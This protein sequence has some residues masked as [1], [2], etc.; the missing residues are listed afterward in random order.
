[1][2]AVF[3]EEQRLFQRT[4]REFLEKECPPKAVR[5]AVSAEAGWSFERW[6]GLADLGVVGLTAPEK[7]GGLGKDETDLV[8]LLEE[9]GRAAL[10]E[11][12][13]ET[14]AVAIPMLS[15]PITEE[16]LE[17]WLARIVS[18][19]AIATLVPTT[20]NA[21]H[22]RLLASDGTQ[23]NLASAEAVL[24]GEAVTQFDRA[25]LATAAELCGI[26]DRVIE[27]AA[28]YA[29]ERQQFGKQIGS[30]QAVKHLLA[31]AL[32]GLDFARPEVYR[33]ACALA[34]G[35]ENV[36][37]NISLA[38]ARASEATVDACRAALQV[39]GAIGYT[40]EHDLHLWL[41]KGFALARRWGTAAWHR[42]RVA[43]SVLG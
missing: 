3:S 43:R 28:T 38:K 5:A 13:A 20:D 15:D 11:P 25:A 7:E 42:E 6:K 10:P 32:L 18:G 31:D 35:S 30:F 19:D 34:Q 21:T 2:N 4:V 27:M 14:T 22:L 26:S 40:H 29:K 23:R 9:A 1:M 41:T 24:G 39:H 17:G 36:V 16:L 8:L 12:L 33:A 37:R